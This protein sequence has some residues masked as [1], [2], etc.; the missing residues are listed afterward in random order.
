MFESQELQAAFDLYVLRPTQ[1]NAT[2]LRKLVGDALLTRRVSVI[3]P[4]L[5]VFEVL[6]D[7]G[8]FPAC[9]H[10]LAFWWPWLMHRKF[11]PDRPGWNDYY[12]VRWILTRE[13]AA[14]DEIHKRAAHVGYARSIT[15][16]TADSGPWDY[17]GAT[18]AWMAKCQREENPEFDAA[19]RRAEMACYCSTDKVGSP[20]D[21]RKLRGWR[22]LKHRLGIEATEKRTGV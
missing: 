21:R 5:A 14:A 8:Q 11:E 1:A 3:G 4:C 17:V 7:R 15:E 6:L 16:L 10:A 12:M 18:A 2:A 9:R 20:E 13:Q 22:W 19:L